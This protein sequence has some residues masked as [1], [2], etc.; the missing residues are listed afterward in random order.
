MSARAVDMTGVVSGRWTVL[1]YA[2]TKGSGGMAVWLCQCECGEIREIFGVVLRNGKSLSCGCWQK[3]GIAARNRK[4][5]LFGSRTYVTWR[6]MLQR[7]YNPD[8][9]S[10]KN[11]GGRGI[12]VCKLWRQDFREF[13]H[14]MGERPDGKTLDRIDNDGGYSTNNCRWATP[15]EQANN[16]RGGAKNLALFVKERIRP[17]EGMNQ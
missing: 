4:H 5:G 8:S 16:K 1:S 9:P 13:L 3:E 12:S 17:T 15:I 11:Y 6:C 10:F 7:C 14:D 2:G